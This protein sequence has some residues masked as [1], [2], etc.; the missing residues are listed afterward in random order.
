MTTKF[1]QGA[2]CNHPWQAFLI[3][4]GAGSGEG[5]GGGV[6]L[7][8]VYSYA[9]V[10]M[11]T[12]IPMHAHFRCYPCMCVCPRPW[13]S[14]LT[15]E[16]TPTCH[17]AP[18]SAGI[19]WYSGG[20]TTTPGSFRCERQL[21]ITYKCVDFFGIQAMRHILYRK[22]LFPH[23]PRMAGERSRRHRH[24]WI[25]RLRMD[26]HVVIGIC[27]HRHIHKRTHC[28]HE[29]TRVGMDTQA[30]TRVPHVSAVV[31]MPHAWIHRDTGI[32]KGA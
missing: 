6:H 9:C 10:S 17:H 12:S 8:I 19:S 26:T 15:P 23:T 20:H 11:P 7:C 21:L 22:V 14:M 24:A 32:H 3:Y 2:A 5:G 1:P 29:F 16:H 18:I 30:Y 25:Q 31:G 27:I 28:T 4:Q 13:V